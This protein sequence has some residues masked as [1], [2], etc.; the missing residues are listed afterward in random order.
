[1]FEDFQFSQFQ[2]DKYHE[3]AYRDLKIAKE[4]E[5][6]EVMFKFSYDVLI[7]T[8][9]AICAKNNLRIKSRQGHHYELINKLAEILNDSEIRVIGNEMRYK[10]NKDLYEGGLMIDWK[11][12]RGYLDWVEE[13]FISAEKYLSKDK[14]L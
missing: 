12:A 4:T 13:I 8:A 5:I 11:Q 3:A 7:K 6:S 14:L 10:R 1:M 9:I 2:I